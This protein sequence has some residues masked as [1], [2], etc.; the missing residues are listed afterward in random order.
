MHG[1]LCAYFLRIATSRLVSATHLRANSSSVKRVADLRARLRIAS[2]S[3]CDS[4]F[5]NPWANSSADV[6]W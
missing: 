2:G 6:A 5:S 3:G 4:A 1:Y